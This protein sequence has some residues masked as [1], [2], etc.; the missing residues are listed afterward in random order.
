MEGKIC[1]KCKQWKPMEKYSRDKRSKDGKQ[2]KCKDCEKQYREANKEKIK[3]YKE[4]YRIENKEKVKKAH[5]D[6]GER[7]RERKNQYN[8]ERYE[9]KKLEI[10]EKQKLYRLKNK[11]KIS[12]AQG[13]YYRKNKEKRK[14]Y[15]KQYGE[16]NKIKISEHNKEYYIKKKKENIKNITRELNLMQTKDKS[17]LF[18]GC[19]YKITHKNGHCYIG[20]TIKPLKHRYKGGIIKGW[21][22][23]RK[24]KLNQKFKDELIAENFTVEIIDYGINQYHLNILEVY[25]INYYDSYNNGYNNNGGHYKDDTG[26]EEFYNKL[27]ENNLQ[28]KNGQL[29]KMEA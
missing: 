25:W 19:I 15:N 12:E 16:K 27:K 20:Q 14:Q 7:N 18:Y 29:L 6:W 4:K 22:K 24:E 5:K 9:A 17:T 26:K 8:K 28:F 21:I 1:T 13:K 10:L 3:L 2:C 23:E 11:E